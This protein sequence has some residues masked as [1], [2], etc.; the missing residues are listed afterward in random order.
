VKIDANLFK[1]RIRNFMMQLNSF[2]IY[3]LGLIKKFLNIKVAQQNKYD[4]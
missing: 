3:I 2:L 1:I 4:P